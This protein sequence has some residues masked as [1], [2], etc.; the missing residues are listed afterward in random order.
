M[1]TVTFDVNVTWKSGKVTNHISK[2]VNVDPDETDE[3][4]L[5]EH[6]AQFGNFKKAVKVDVKKL[7]VGPDEDPVKVIQA[8]PKYFSGD[9]QIQPSGPH[10]APPAPAPATPAAVPAVP[11]VPAAAPP[12]AS[13]SAPAVAPAPK[14]PAA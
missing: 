13:S 6:F 9:K 7:G 11:P 3:N 12:S 1:A 4:T 14:T 10:A 8:G 2:M 5:V